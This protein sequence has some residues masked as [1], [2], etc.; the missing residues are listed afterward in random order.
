MDAKSN[1]T[2]GPTE[3]VFT[4]R[5]LGKYDVAFFRCPET[6]YVQTEKPYWLE[7]AY[8]SPMNLCDTG[9]LMRNTH[10][11]TVLRAF[12][13][14]F[15]VSEGQFLDYAGGYGVFTRMMRDAGLDYYWDD[16]YTQNVLARGFEHAAGA[17]TYAALSA[18]EVFEHLVNP[19]EE[20]VGLFKLAPT[21]LFSTVLLPE[22]RPEAADWWYYGLSHGQHVSFY[23]VRALEVLAREHGAT[24]VSNGH[25]LHAFLQR[26]LLP[27]EVDADWFRKW[28]AREGRE[29]AAAVSRAFEFCPKLH[30]GRKLKHRLRNLV[31]RCRFNAPGVYVLKVLP[32]APDYVALTASSLAV[33]YA[34]YLLSGGAVDRGRLAERFP[35]LT[36]PDMERLA[37]RMAA[38]K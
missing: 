17:R 25:D 1:I 3:R 36:I 29:Y 23:T 27:V 16:P 12:L 19:R 38:Q 11:S 20:I 4:A 31:R 18:I 35:S 14:A 15:F 28:F 5:V 21:V 33:G 32:G 30:G 9:V 8:K 7:E 22:P 37:Q 2:G 26:D 13:G 10:F 6:G 34:A 24:L